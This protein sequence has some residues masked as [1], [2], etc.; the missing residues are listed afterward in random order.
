MSV[1]SF[2]QS[3]HPL[4]RLF[5]VVTI[6]VIVLPASLWGIVQLYE[7]LCAWL[8]GC[9]AMTRPRGPKEG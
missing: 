8:G 3:K 2:A 5:F 9:E 7:T 1:D 6:F 4:W